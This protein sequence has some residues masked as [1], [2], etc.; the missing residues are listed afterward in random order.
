MNKD[1]AA[2]FILRPSAF[3]L[4]FDFPGVAGRLVRGEPP[5][6]EPNAE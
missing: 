6:A 2:G 3:F 4:H 1:P 5:A